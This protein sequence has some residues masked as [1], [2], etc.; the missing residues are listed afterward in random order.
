MLD[1]FAQK[2]IKK[3]ESDYNLI[4]PH[5]SQTRQ[6]DWPEFQ[7]LH[8]L[9]KPEDQVLDVGC[10]NGRLAEIIEKI[11]GYYTGLDVSKKLITEGKKLYPDIKLVQG[12]MLELPF[13]N[14]EFNVTIA[15]ASLQHIPS[16]KY[17]LQAL[18]EMSRVTKPGGSLF[19]MN[20]NLYQPA[21]PDY[22]TNVP[23]EFENGDAIVPWKNEQG[24][25][26]AERYYHGFTIPELNE[27]LDDASWKNA[28]NFYSTNNEKTDQ[29]LGRNIITIAKK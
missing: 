24:E 19:M 21:L 6:H 25:V 14:E 26:L 3:V 22:F 23:N 17:R 20:W 10:G 11:K 2:L 7:L 12:S 27:L 18:Q 16:K 4:A 28:D 9:V 13:A 8:K 15:I 5:F 29:K 1:S